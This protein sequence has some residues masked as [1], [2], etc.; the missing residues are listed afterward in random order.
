MAEL[1]V[2]IRDALILF[3]LFF[4]RGVLTFFAFQLGAIARFGFGIRGTD[5]K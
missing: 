5:V 4:G 3:Y 1:I 2:V